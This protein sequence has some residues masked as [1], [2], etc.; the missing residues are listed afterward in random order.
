MTALV[1]IVIPTHND[2]HCLDSAV[3]SCL[4]QSYDNFEVVVVDDGSESTVQ[5]PSDLMDG[6]VKVI[7]IDHSGPGAARNAGIRATRGDFIKFLDADDSLFRDCIDR[8]VSALSGT[9][10]T[11]SI[12]G[13]RLSLENGRF[14]DVFPKFDRFGEAVLI[15]F[16]AALN[17]FLYPRSLILEAGGFSTA[18]QVRQ[19]NEDWEFNSRMAA[20]EPDVVSL[21]QVLVQ[22]NLRADSRVH[23]PEAMR[24]SQR[25]VATENL[26]RLVVSE[27]IQP[28]RIAL[29]LLKLAAVQK[30]ASY[31]H[32][33]T[34]LQKLVE[35]STALINNHI[36]P[37]PAALGER[38][39][40]FFGEHLFDGDV[41]G[42][43]SP[44]ADERA[45]EWVTD[46]TTR[47]SLLAVD[48]P[49]QFA[50]ERLLAEFVKKTQACDKILVWGGGDWGRLTVAFLNAIG[51]EGRIL[52]YDKGGRTSGFSDSNIQI[53][54]SR[55]Q[56]VGENPQGIIIASNR[57]FEE[58]KI[59]IEELGMGNRILAIPA[60]SL[61]S[62]AQKA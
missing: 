13:Y 47:S 23:Q 40:A 42:M 62:G 27:N 33:D 59:E 4:E 31:T 30:D 8:E 50:N 35:Q 22:Y 37:C 29:G 25:W 55:K 51:F 48:G 1:S 12:C 53:L 6:R 36:D 20:L 10:R 24:R 19:G 5:L 11:M 7:R 17:A 52:L 56:I 58:I 16:V 26:Q 54:N 45:L 32:W 57:F 15:G 3:R 43:V 41:A 60:S 9:E 28:A 44:G 14:R 2:Q 18:T 38:L 39:I 46:F 61:G 49:D 21:H 34:E